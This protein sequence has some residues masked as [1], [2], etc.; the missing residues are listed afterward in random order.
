MPGINLTA[1]FRFEYQRLFDT[2]NIRPEKLSEIEKIIQKI[3][4]NK[5]RYE[6][7]G[8][9]LSI[10]WYVI[11]SIHNMESSLNFNCH[12]HN[13]DSL[14]ARTRNV[15]AGRPLTGNPPFTWEESARDSLTLQRLN[16]WSDWSIPGILYKIEE[17]N[18]WGYRNRHPEVLTPYLWS[19]SVH[20]VKGKFVA[21]GRWSDTAISNQIGA[22]VIIRRLVEKNLISFNRIEI[23]D[24]NMPLVYY[25]S[26]KIEHGERLQEFL[27]QFPDIYLLIDGKIGEKTSDALKLVTGNYLYGDPRV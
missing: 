25:S 11:A 18:G 12:L 14:T 3:T 17:Y 13:G 9:Q 23:K 5:T 19:G 1:A 26:K 15:P 20:Y 7:V 21:D 10:P 24:S 27:N 22:G 16:I 8:A 4:N 6:N 2:C